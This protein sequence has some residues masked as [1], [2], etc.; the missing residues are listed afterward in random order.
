MSKGSKII[1]SH[2]WAKLRL[3][4][5]NRDSYTCAYCGLE[6]NEVDH[7]V[8]LAVNPDLAFDMDNLVACCRTCNN[9]KGGRHKGVFL[10]RHLTPPVSAGSLSPITTTRVV[11]DGFANAPKPI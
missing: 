10:R 1:Q 4:I 2:Q 7:V 11:S 8:P 5:L 3:V 6:A 9:K